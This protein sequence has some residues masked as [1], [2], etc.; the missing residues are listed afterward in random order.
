M[1]L[2]EPLWTKSLRL[3]QG[4]RDPLALSR[5]PER[6]TA[7]LVPGIISTTDIARHYSFY[8]WAISDVLSKN[9]IKNR[10][11]FRKEFCKRESAYVLASMFHEEQSSEK[12]P[13]QGIEE[14]GHKLSSNEGQS[15][16]VGFS[17]SKSNPEGIYGL[18]YKNAM[19]NLGLTIRSRVF[20][21]LTPAGK[22]LAKRFEN[23]ISDTEYFRSWTLEQDIPLD[24]LREYGNLVCPCLLGRMGSERDLLESC[25][26]SENLRLFDFEKSRR[27]TLG[28]ILSMI[29]V[30]NQEEISF[31]ERQFREGILF[32]KF[33]KSHTFVHFDDQRFKDIQSLW[34]F[35]QLEENIIYS[36]E[37]ILHIFLETIKVD[38]SGRSLD[39]VIVTFEK[40]LEAVYRVLDVPP[41]ERL[42]ELLSLVLGSDANEF[43]KPDCSGLSRKL[44]P[45]KGI[46]EIQ[47]CFNIDES[48]EKGRLHEAFGASVSILLLTY[49]R[50]YQY[51]EGFD[52]GF[53]WYQDKSCS[54]LSLY[55]LADGIKALPR[56]SSMVDF[57]RF[58]LEKI[59]YQHNIVAYDK[60]DYG[61]YTFRFEQRGRQLVF[62]EGI[63]PSYPAWRNSHLDQMLAILTDLDLI[64]RV[65]DQCSLTIRGKQRLST[66]GRSN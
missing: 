2:L 18:Y 1:A 44:D 34:R 48:L 53:L 56:S 9:T 6:I 35:F 37:T 12:R 24:V 42:F 23:H 52:K 17:V 51:L 31:G 54:E 22:E 20:D 40:Y 5:V 65:D 36:L 61:N 58:L 27:E 66:Y 39:E 55:T 8:C 30:C 29:D 41:T 15:I 47:L 3:A 49:L 26:F 16:D 4:K 46:D 21:D 62:K 28:L 25:F 10:V 32:S 14:A 33:R 13:L 38:E 57:F 50:F 45:S 43:P 64:E 60:L 63:Y 19:S 59:Y 11:L 7:Q